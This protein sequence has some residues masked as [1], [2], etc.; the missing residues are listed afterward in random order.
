MLGWYEVE[1]VASSRAQR[2]VEQIATARLLVA[3]SI[4]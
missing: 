2:R 1:T 4:P 3:L